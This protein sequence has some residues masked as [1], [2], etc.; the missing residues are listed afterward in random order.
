MEIIINLIVATLILKSI[1][2]LIK[3]FFY[4]LLKEDVRL[5]YKGSYLLVI[6]LLLILIYIYKSSKHLKDSC[7]RYSIKQIIK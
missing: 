2:L 5:S 3:D 1:K 6:M 7:I 4:A